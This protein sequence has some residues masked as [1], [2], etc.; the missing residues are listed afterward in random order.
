MVVSQ[1][2]GHYSVSNLPAG[3]YVVQGVGGGYQS[4]GSAPVDVAEG[5]TAKLDFRWPPSEGPALPRAWPMKTPEAQMV[6]VSKDLPEGDGK[7][8]VATRC[9]TCHETERFVGFHMRAI[10]GRSPC[11]GCAAVCER[12]K[13]RD[14]TQTRPSSRSTT[15]QPTS[16]LCAQWTSTIACRTLLKEKP[17][18]PAVQYEHLGTS[19]GASR[20]TFAVDPTETDG[21]ASGRPSWAAWIPKRSNT[22][23]FPFQPASQAEDGQVLGNLQIDAKGQ[24]W[25]RTDPT[26]VGCSTTSTRGNSLHTMAKD[27][28]ADAGGNSMLV[29]PNGSIWETAEI[30]CA[31]STRRRRN[32]VL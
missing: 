19:V 32:Q 21:S 15:F 18:L 17:A 28:H 5:K 3:H 1:A 25:F 10:A 8:I 2:Q 26:I 11:A 23:K 13:I 6:T 27:N 12:A 30:K 31:C 29:H 16:R 24:L 9:V 22:P 7:G 4:N 14:L 20:M